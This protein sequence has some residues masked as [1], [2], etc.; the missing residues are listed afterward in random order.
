MPITIRQITLIIISL[1]LSTGISGQDKKFTLKQAQEYAV[2]HSYSVKN[3]SFEL[4]K[5]DKQV[6]EVMAQGLPQLAATMDYNYFIQL[7]TSLIPAEFF[8]GEEGEF[9]EAQF[10]TKNNLNM[11]IKL[12]Q[13][14]FDGRYFI[15]LQYSKI[16]KQL[17]ERNLRKSEIDIKALVAETYYNI[18]VGQQSLIVLDSTLS[19]LEQ[20][21]FETGEMLKEGFVEETDYD[22]LTLTVSDIQNSHNSVARQTEISIS[23]L[24]FQMGIPL[25]EPVTLSETLDDVLVQINLEEVANAQFQMGSNIDYLMISSQEEM[26]ILKIKNEKANYWPSLNGYFLFTQNAQREEFNF[27]AA[28]LPWFP[29]TSVG[30]NMSIPIF[31]SGMR[32]ARV[33]QAKLELD[34][35]RNNKAEVEQGLNMSV[36]TARSVFNTALENF[37]REERSVE[38]SLKIYQRA[39][40]KYQ[41]GMITSA[42]MTQHHNQFFDSESNYFKT[43][44]AL[45]YAKNELD[46]TL[47]NY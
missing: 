3:A 25:E 2:E 44:L 16:Y 34:Q 35:I 15:G 21:R 42:E 6:K 31:S 43:V 10:G 1:L 26:K 28:G 41:E 17:S 39:L 22:Q 4:V 24:K 37:Y 27:T 45:L 19:V 29:T 40:I 13:L 5:A 38:L 47:G 33:D 46:R 9:F 11:G 23:L 7:P 12:D 18:L 32:K 20:I 14:I 8:G 30:V 36:F